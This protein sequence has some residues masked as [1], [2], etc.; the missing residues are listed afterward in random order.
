M[1]PTLAQQI[2]VG[3][4]KVFELI[5]SGELNPGGRWNAA[6]RRRIDTATWPRR[7]SAFKI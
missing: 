2:C 3:K 4:T 1:K 7:L 6:R 5:K